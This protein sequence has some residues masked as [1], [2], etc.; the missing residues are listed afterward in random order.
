[1]IC[2]EIQLTQRQPDK[3][4]VRLVTMFQKKLNGFEY[5]LL[6]DGEQVGRT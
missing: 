5:H 3:D 4:L 6:V 2:G 1:M